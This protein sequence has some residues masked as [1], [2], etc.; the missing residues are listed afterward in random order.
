MLRVVRVHLALV[1]RCKH[2]RV[3]SHTSDE[4]RKVHPITTSLDGCTSVAQRGRAQMARRLQAFGPQESVAAGPV[5]TWPLPSCGRIPCR[6]ADLLQRHGHTGSSSCRPRL[7][8][9]RSRSAVDAFRARCPAQC[10]PGSRR[11]WHDRVDRG[12]RLRGLNHREGEPFLGC[13]AFRS[14]WSPHCGSCR[15]QIQAGYCLGHR[16]AAFPQ[17]THPPG[18]LPARSPAQCGRRLPLDVAGAREE[19]LASAGRGCPS[20]PIRDGGADHGQ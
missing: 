1:P 6:T 17:E 18:R 5:E 9:P 11:P 14:R 16:S 13:A 7:A 4:G 8:R 3:T 15:K 10:R 2:L 19:H 20:A 12:S